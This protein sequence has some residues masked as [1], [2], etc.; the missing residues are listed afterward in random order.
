MICAYEVKMS[1]SVKDAWFKSAYA[2]LYHVPAHKPFPRYFVCYMSYTY[3]SQVCIL[4]ATKF[5]EITDQSLNPITHKGKGPAHYP[6]ALA[7]I[8]FY[9]INAPIN[10]DHYSKWVSDMFLRSWSVDNAH[11]RYGLDYEFW[12]EVKQATNIELIRRSNLESSVKG[13]IIN[14]YCMK[15]LFD[16][17]W[18]K[19]YQI[20]G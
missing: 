19:A 12:L 15:E 5:G 14:H 18:S 3:G 6:D 9:V 7:S 8:G 10:Y 11:W 20:K 13:E 2:K 4:P 16:L 17:T 1:D